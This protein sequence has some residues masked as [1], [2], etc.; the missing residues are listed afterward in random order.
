MGFAPVGMSCLWFK[1]L[2][3][4]FLQQFEGK[5]KKTGSP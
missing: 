5:G 1:N 2:S 4:D 3:T